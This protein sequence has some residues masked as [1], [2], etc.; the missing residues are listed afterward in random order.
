MTHLSRW[1]LALT[2]AFITVAASAQT[3][4]RCGLTDQPAATVLLPY[5]EVDLENPQGRNT[6]F[7]VSNVYTR[8]TLAHAVMWTNL[9]IPILSF[10]LVIP[11]E[12][13]RTMSV[14]NL[15]QGNLP[16]TSPPSMPP[17]GIFES[18]KDPL[19]NPAVDVGLLTSLLTGGPHPDDGL[20]YASVVEDGALA[21][22][23]ITVD[24]VRACSNGEVR[25]PR[26][27]GYFQDGGGGL[28]TNDNALIGDFFLVDEANNF[29]QGEALV[30]VVAD[31]SRFGE[32]VVCVVEPCPPRNPFTFYGVED[33]GNR[34]PLPSAYRSRFLRGGGFSGGTDLLVWLG[35]STSR[36]NFADPIECGFKP[37]AIFYRSTIRSEAGGAAINHQSGVPARVFRAAVGGELLPT[38]L[39]FGHVDL[40]ANIQS[41]VVLPVPFEMQ[42]W[43]MPLHS[44]SGRYSVGLSATPISDFC[45]EIP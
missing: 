25:T 2:V 1:I 5:F 29:A 16:S 31:A 12:G 27:A 9:G 41:G 43:V 35:D 19:A 28:G 39:S 22:G 4:S 7:S 37:Q 42:L 10:D 20:C 45:S 38:D 34:M 6:L 15:I 26:D 33:P 18:C 8:A 3:A 17:S 36:A 30:S 11:A 40:S 13:V 14:R 24:V 23:Y 44:A 32:T 21:T